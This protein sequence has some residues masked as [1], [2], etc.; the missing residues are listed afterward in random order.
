MKTSDISQFSLVPL[1]TEGEWNRPLLENAAALSDASCV[2]ASSGTAAAGALQNGTRLLDEVLDG[3]QHIVACEAVR[4]SKSVYAL[5]APRGSTAV[6][7]G[8][9]EKGVP[10]SVLKRTDA[11]VVVPMAGAAMSS[12]NVAVSA[13]VV[14][15]AFSKDL[16]RRKK[17]PCRLRRRDIDVLIDAP[18]D[19]HELGSLLRSAWAF[20]WRRIFV[21][22]EHH[23]WFSEDPKVI[24]EGRAAARRA[25]NPIAVLPADR[26]DP[27]DYEGIAVCDGRREGMPLSRWRLP[28]CDRLLMV[29][30]S[31]AHGAR[32]DVERVYVDY[33]NA[34]VEPRFRHSGSIL[35]SMISELS[36]A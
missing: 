2:F 11:V 33:V 6:I 24:L 29:V 32:P 17:P 34:V 20:G 28:A 30:G 3:F 27:A 23:V 22:D 12:V 4:D 18:P 10:R 7:V 9:E 21:A 8:N 1:D 35:L 15:Y 13:A 26:L 5:P 36:G 31:G 14:L 25:K 19:P 16:G